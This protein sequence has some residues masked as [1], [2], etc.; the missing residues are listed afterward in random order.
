MCVAARNHEKF[1]KT[2]NFWGS[3]L[4]KN[5]DVDKTKK[6]VTSACYDSNT[7]VYLSATVLTL[8]EPITAK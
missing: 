7:S 4:F 6:P 3:R 8:D 5:I 1:T 2:L